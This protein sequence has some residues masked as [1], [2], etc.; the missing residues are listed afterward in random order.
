MKPSECFEV[1]RIRLT[2]IT[3]V[4]IGSRLGILYPMEFFFYQNQVYVVN[5]EKLGRF[6]IEKNLMDK[7]I[8]EAFS[9]NLRRDGILQ[10]IQKN[11]GGSNLPNLMSLSSY[12]VP[13]GS[14]KMG[15]FRPFI[16]DGLNRIYI[17]GTSIKGVMRTAVLYNVVKNNIGSWEKKI[18][19]QIKEARNRERGKTFSSEMQKS[20]LQ[21]F[22]LAGSPVNDQNKDILRCLIVRD[23]YP[24]GKPEVKVIP[25]RVLCKRKEGN[26]YWSTG[27]SRNGE[28]VI[29]VE[30]VVGGIFETEIVWDYALYQKFSEKNRTLPVTCIK[31]VLKCVSQMQTDVMKHEIEFFKVKKS[32][33][34][35]D[36]AASSLRNWYQNALNGSWLRIGYGSGMLSTTVDLLWNESLRQKIRNICGKDRRDDPAPKS[37]RVWQR[38]DVQCFPVGWMKLEVSYGKSGEN[39]EIVEPP[40]KVE[41]PP[42]ESGDSIQKQISEDSARGITASLKISSRELISAQTSSKPVQK[43]QTRQGIL[44]REGDKW[45]ARF[46]GDDRLAEIENQGKIPDAAKSESVAEFYIVAQSKQKGI[47]ARFQKLINK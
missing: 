26:F 7:F 24:I 42:G 9:G 10:F 32:S 34:I 27:S 40:V 30:A 36:S 6:L 11:T 43:G 5:E 47:I 41:L 29:W 37:R 1:A 14:A 2:V 18:D 21:S 46:E 28:I 35:A 45:V 17:P 12:S 39:W 20:F 44:I 33:D 19:E 16:R 13:G 22:T 15:E 31:D 25:I 8:N 23:A 4:F 38:N 3:P